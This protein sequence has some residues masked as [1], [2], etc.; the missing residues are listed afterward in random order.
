MIKNF[1]KILLPLFC[2]FGCLFL[3]LISGFLGFDKE[4][5][6]YLLLLLTFLIVYI[7]IPLQVLFLLIKIILVLLKRKKA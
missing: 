4:G 2:I 6:G 1:P 7:F 3:M 5:E